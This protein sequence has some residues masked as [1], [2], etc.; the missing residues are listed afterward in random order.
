MRPCHPSAAWPHPCTQIGLGEFPDIRV[1]LTLD[2]DPV[3]LGIGRLPPLGLLPCV[4]VT[5]ALLALIRVLIELVRAEDLEL[6]LGGQRDSHLPCLHLL[7]D[8]VQQLP[9]PGLPLAQHPVLPAQVTA[10][11]RLWIGEDLRYLVQSE[12]QLAVE[13]D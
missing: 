6:L 3:G 5:P 1:R 2:R 9:V 10:A 13:Q 8:R 12:I 4:R 7:L 11:P